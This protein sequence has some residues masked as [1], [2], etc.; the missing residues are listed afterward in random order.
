MFAPK[1]SQ[2]FVAPSAQVAGERFT[3]E[4]NACGYG[5]HPHRDL[6]IVHHRQV[7]FQGPIGQGQS[8]HHR[9]AHPFQ[10]L[11]IELGQD[12][13]MHIDAIGFFGINRLFFVHDH[14]SFTSGWIPLWGDR[15]PCVAQTKRRNGRV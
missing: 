11:E 7:F 13:M 9:T 6:V 15:L 1:G 3:L 4:I 2:E 14:L 8:E 5:C 10:Y 12:M